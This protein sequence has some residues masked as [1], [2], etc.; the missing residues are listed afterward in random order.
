M[1]RS[2]L[3][4]LVATFVPLAATGSPAADATWIAREAT[5]SRITLVDV[6]GSSPQ[7]IL[8]S[9]HRYSAPD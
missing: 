3:A 1:V 8:E 4:L 7:V 9:P 6:N 2:N 5:R